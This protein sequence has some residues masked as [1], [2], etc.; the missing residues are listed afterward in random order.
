MSS[1]LECPYQVYNSPRGVG[2]C[3]YSDTQVSD[4]E[5]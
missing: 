2:T 4:R 1:R 5:V 3:Y